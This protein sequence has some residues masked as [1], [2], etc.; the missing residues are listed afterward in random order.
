MSVLSSFFTF[1]NYVRTTVWMHDATL[2]RALGTL[3]SQLDTA[4]QT[5]ILEAR[6]I[7]LA[8]EEYSFK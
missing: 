5:G 1:K 4:Y 6:G 7:I 3:A 2:H 8:I